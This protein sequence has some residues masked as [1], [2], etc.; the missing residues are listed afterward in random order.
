MVNSPWALW[1]PSQTQYTHS[2]AGL[3][4]AIHPSESPNRG[5]KLLSVNSL[6]DAMSLE[7]KEDPC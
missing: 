2:N 1:P 3:P 5:N 6:K 4:I 7:D